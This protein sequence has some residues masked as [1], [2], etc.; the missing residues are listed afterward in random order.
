MTRARRIGILL[1]ALCLGLYLGAMP[2]GEAEACSLCRLTVSSKKSRA[3][4]EVASI[5]L[6]V[7]GMMKSRSGAT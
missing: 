6:V 4:G 2:G 7:K 5:T 1:M 3:N